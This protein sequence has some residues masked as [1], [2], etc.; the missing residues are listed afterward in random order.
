MVY[1]VID[2]LP[3]NVSKTILQHLTEKEDE[4]LAAFPPEYAG[5]IRGISAAIKMDLPALILY[6]IAYELEGACTSIVAQ[7]AT[8]HPFHARNLDFGLF[9]G[10]DQANRTWQLAEKLRPLLFN[11]RFVKGGRTLYNSTAYAGFV[12]LL[13]GMKHGGFSITVDT[14]FDLNL[15]K[16]LFQWLSGDHSGHFLAFTTRTVMET[17]A[18]YDDALTALNDTKMVGPSY[19]ILGGVESGEGAVITREEALSLHLWTIKN[20][21]RHKDFYVLQ[22]NYD[23]WVEAPFFGE[24]PQSPPLLLFGGV[25]LIE[26]RRQ[27]HVSL[28]SAARCTCHERTDDRRDPAMKCMDAMGPSGVGFPN[29]FNVLS[30]EPNLNLLTTY[31][32]LMDVKNGHF[33]A[34]RQACKTHPCAPW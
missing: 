3:A 32:T 26:W 10:W 19:I 20:N 7:D 18:T 28:T 11:A 15:D 13:T 17:I 30:H 2:R 25:Y 33:E 22:T 14:R 16:G 5:E 21:L 29:L 27:V 1:S 23:N 8:G 9:L 31:T 4:I 24:L 34:Y 6:N 12:G